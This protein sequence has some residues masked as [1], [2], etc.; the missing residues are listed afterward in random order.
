MAGYGY[1]PPERDGN[2]LSD[3]KS[4]LAQPTSS[5]EDMAPSL[6]DEVRSTRRDLIDLQEQVS[7]LREEFRVTQTNLTKFYAKV[8]GS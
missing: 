5:G 4:Q 7:A 8:F 2:Q 6:D 3:G 1:G